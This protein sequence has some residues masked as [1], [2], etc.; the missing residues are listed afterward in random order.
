MAA[1]S[2]FTHSLTAGERSGQNS[3]LSVRQSACPSV[4]AHFGIPDLLPKFEFD[5]TI[6]IRRL[7]AGWV[8]GSLSSFRLRYTQEH[9]HTR[10]IEFTCP[11]VDSPLHGG[12]GAPPTTKR[13]MDRKSDGDGD[14]GDDDG[15]G[16]VAVAEE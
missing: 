14:G 15:T 3:S 11:G 10:V 2:P 12:T 16:G 7:Y 1:Q 8:Y 13:R 4:G 6:S 9:T 5:F